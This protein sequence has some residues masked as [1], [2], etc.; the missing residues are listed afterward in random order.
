MFN[1]EEREFLF[2]EI[3]CN[4]V[5]KS[6]AS[7]SLAKCFGYYFKQINRKNGAIKVVKK[8]SKTTNFGGL[9]GLKSLWEIS[10]KAENAKAREHCQG[11][12]ID[13]HLKLQE[14]DDLVTIEFVNNCMNN[15]N[16]E[17]VIS[18]LS[19]FM[20]R[21]EGKKDLKPEMSLVSR[22]QGIKPIAL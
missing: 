18:L 1:A 21:Y 17:G 11:V 9:K 14:P 8:V 10:L 20:D 2:S 15:S 22:V 7:L 6:N 4:S 3:L 19:T 5:T 16:N 12:L 13:V